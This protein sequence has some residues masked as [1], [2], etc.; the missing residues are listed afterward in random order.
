MSEYDKVLQDLKIH[1]EELQVQNEELKEKE[2]AVNTLYSKYYSLFNNSPIAYLIVDKSL[3]I[4][5]YNTKASMILND[6]LR[7]PS[8]LYMIKYLK[9]KNFLDFHDWLLSDKY[10]E[11]EFFITDL[12]INN[13]STKFKIYASDYNEQEQVYLLTLINI[14]DE[15]NMMDSI[16]KLSHEKENQSKIMMQQA[17]LAAVGEML[18]NIA[19]QWKQPLNNL[20]MLISASKIYFK[21]VLNVDKDKAD[22]INDNFE[23]SL[24]QIIFL[25]E[26][27]NNFNRFFISQNVD[28]S[29]FSL[30]TCIQNLETF[31]FSQFKDNFIH[32]ILE[33]DQIDVYGNQ[34]QLTQVFLNLLSNAKDAL[35]ENNSDDSRYIFLNTH[36]DDDFVYIVIKDTA[37]GIKEEIID[38][39]FEQYFTTKDSDKGTGL[40]LNLTKKI[41]EQQFNGK[42]DVKNEDFKYKNKKY[43]GAVFTIKIPKT[44]K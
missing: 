5:E 21:S 38:S 34:N 32:L 14:Q 23:K 25:S 18:G 15:Y 8:S 1:Q 4:K 16:E 20:S 9:Q 33:A 44:T 11:E 22:L 10:K 30:N 28:E 39:I 12:F 2:V 42:I 29:I 13:T 31:T 7:N 3:K 27:V 40:G 43:T 6:N 35:I 26:T 37:G 17:K 36:V 41:I 19:H 24:S